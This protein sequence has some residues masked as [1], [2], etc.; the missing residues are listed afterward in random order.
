M[1]K[2]SPDQAHLEETVARVLAMVVGAA[3]SAPLR[4]FR[5]PAHSAAGTQIRAGR[6]STPRTVPR[7]LCKTANSAPMRIMYTQ[8]PEHTNDN[9]ADGL[10]KSLQPPPG[11]VR[12]DLVVMHVPD[13]A[14]ALAGRPLEDLVAY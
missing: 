3:P 13:T 5:S 2:G 1:K 7:R 9:V 14:P 6:Q 12:L 10:R 8:I 4:R 11:A